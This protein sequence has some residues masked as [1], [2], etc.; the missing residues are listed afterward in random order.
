[1]RLEPRH[2]AADRRAQPEI[3]HPVDGTAGERVVGTVAA[4]AH[5]INAKG[6]L[7][8]V[9]ETEVRRREADRPPAPVAG[10]DAAVDLPK[11]AEQCRGLARLPRLQQ[12]ADMG[13]GVD[14]SVRVAD[15][16]E[17][18]D[19]KAVPGA[20]RSQQIWCPAAAIAKR[21][22]PPDDEVAGTDRPDDDLRDE[23]LCTLGGKAEVEMLD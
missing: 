11:A 8:I 13:R 22:I 10:G 3:R 12:L 7:Q 6:R 15:R 1:M 14:S 17:N 23:V 5:G 4:D 9:V 21:A 20:L 16:L 19:A 18:G 2:Q